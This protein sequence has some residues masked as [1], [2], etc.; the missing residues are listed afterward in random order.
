M[1]QFDPSE[2]A[3][4]QPVSAAEARAWAG[5]VDLTMSPSATPEQ[6]GAVQ[7][8]LAVSVL[9]DLA[10][11]TRTPSPE[12]PDIL[13]LSDTQL[14]DLLRKGATQSARLSDGDKEAI[15]A[16]GE[17][18]YGVLFQETANAMRVEV[19]LNAAR[20]L[21]A[22]AV[23]YP[24]HQAEL[25]NLLG[26]LA[27]EWGVEVSPLPTKWGAVAVAQR[28]AQDLVTLPSHLRNP[29]RHGW[30]A[31]GGSSGRRTDEPE[32]LAA[33]VPSPRRLWADDYN[34]D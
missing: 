10:A 8:H 25:T 15:R 30:Y 31:G 26:F 28:A 13:P 5:M 33:K 20:T 27:A 11:F 18:R 12:R 23:K 2:I 22:Q 1:T 16:F 17:W 24:D 14:M 32:K 4:Q 9:G 29:E 3:R 7:V 6:R 19:L 21:T 34:D